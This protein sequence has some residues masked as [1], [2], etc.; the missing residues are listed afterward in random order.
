MSKIIRNGIEY[1]GTATTANQVQYSPT[2]TVAD[3]I[4]TLGSIR[5]FSATGSIYGG[6]SC[7]AINGIKCI[8]INNPT[9]LLAN[10]LTTLDFTLPESMRPIDRIHYFDI[11]QP[12]DNYTI[13]LII[14]PNGMVQI[15]NYG[16]TTGTLNMSFT[17]CYI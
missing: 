3:K 17:G 10:S 8:S 13:R 12:S 7:K 16:A 4:N 11:R 6:Y 2:E 9:G 14:N 1:G 5:R 15:Y